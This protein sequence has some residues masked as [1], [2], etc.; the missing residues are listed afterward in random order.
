MCNCGNCNNCEQSKEDFLEEVY[1]N[2]RF[3][4]ELERRGL[5]KIDN[6]VK[7]DN[8]KVPF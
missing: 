1:F 6:K 4:E 8:S 2:K 7:I 5:L 3:N